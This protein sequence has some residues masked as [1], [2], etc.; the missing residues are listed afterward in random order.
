MPPASA[1][2]PGPAIAAAVLGIIGALWYGVDTVRSWDV[3]SSLLSSIGQ[4]SGLELNASM[5]FWAYGSV[6]AVIGQLIFVPVLLLGAILLLSRVP[7]G[8]SLMVLGSVLVLAANIFWAIYGFQAVGSYLSGSGEYLARV[9]VE[10]G[11]PA[12]LAIVALVLVSR[13]STKQWCR[14]PASASY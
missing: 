3:I 11:P 9:L 5:A 4:L 2:Q 10:T 1:A 6:A 14:R 13:S 8:R 7:A 12:L